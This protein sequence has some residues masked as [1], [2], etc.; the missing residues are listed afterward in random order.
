MREFGQT[1]LKVSVLGFGA[2][3][4][5]D[6]KMD[7]SSAETLLN[8]VLDAGITLIDTARGYGL[9]EER[10]G[11]FLSKRRQE[12]VLSTKVGYSVPGFEDWTYDC[13]MAG[14]DLALKTM[15]TDYIDI[16][17]LH[18]CPLETLQKG[19]VVEALQ[20]TVKTGKVR[21]AAYSGENEALEYAISTGA[22][23]SI[24]T[25]INI[26]DQRVIDNGLAQAN[27]KSMGVIAK[28]PIANAPWRFNER[29]VGHYSEVYW[30][31][32][33][34]MNLN[35]HGIDLGELALRF[36]AYLDGV[37]SCIVGTGN[38]EHLKHNVKLVEKGPLPVDMVN[39]IR[40]AFKRHDDNWI[41]Q[42]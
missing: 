28:R 36:T 2:G 6:S 16:V 23:G 14:V 30:E 11:K 21:V 29:P 24:Q 18:S 8:E 40:A 19:E 7:D 37:S 10:I 4:I 1:G 27:T 32:L 22:F 15:K 31:R 42:V 33:Q 3:H 25:S 26:C 34:K 5:G 9:S 13:I 20:E 41:G 17:H 39:E 38:L 35:P 12:F